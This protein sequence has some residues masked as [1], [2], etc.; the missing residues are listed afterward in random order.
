MYYQEPENTLKSLQ[1]AI[2]LFDGIEFDIRMTSDNQLIVHHDRSVSI[3]KSRLQGKS[4]WVE[5]WK[6]EDLESEGF[7]SFRAMLE[8]PIIRSNWVEK[9]KMGCIE[10]KR[11]H[12]IAPMG[13]GFLSRKKH[14]NH[15]ANII[16]MADEILDEFEVPSQNMVYY[17][18]HKGMKL[19]AKSANSKRPWAA[20]IPYIAPYGNRTT[21]RFQSL[22]RYLTTSFSSLTKQHN[23]MGSSM[24]PCAIEYFLPPH[25]KL[26]IGKTVGLT[27]K[28]LTN[29]N[30]T[31][32]G[33][34]TY[35]W[36]TKPMYEKKILDAGL[37]GL[38]D[39]ANPQLTWLPSG[40]ARWVNP[41]IQP[42]DK[43]Q[44]ILLNSASEENHLEI[45]KQLKHEVP[46]WSEC[47]ASR[48]LELVSMW[49][50][51]WNW[52]KSVDEILK[53]ATMTSPLWQAPRLIG[54]R[55]SGKTPRPVIDD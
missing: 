7:I 23:N 28:Q 10:I 34:P 53:S 4:E 40:D 26:P 22:P 47:D 31:R 13:G 21:Q 19:S 44:Q 55:G 41:A 46:L 25:N 38:T 50:K 49:K 45:L 42:L 11:P 27:G 29:L 2:A 52:Q 14:N 39:K 43:Q 48:R 15:V 8:D 1:H 35:V 54:H 51:S 12:P 33:M 24:L 20:L 32:K 36:P 6:L 9:G 30:T 18:F 5:A 17:A 37:T 16:K 3:K